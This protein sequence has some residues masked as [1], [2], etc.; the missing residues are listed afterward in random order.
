MLTVFKSSGF[1]YGEPLKILDTGLLCLR[2]H[3][4]A[5]GQLKLLFF[6]IVWLVLDEND[7]PGTDTAPPAGLVVH[8]MILVAWPETFWTQVLG[9]SNT[10]FSSLCSLTPHYKIIQGLASVFYLARV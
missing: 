3:P 2:K 5:Q 8:C 1:C 4:I 7:G 9:Y 10:I 6:K